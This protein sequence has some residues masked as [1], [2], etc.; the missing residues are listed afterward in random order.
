M[1]MKEK[2]ELSGQ[3]DLEKHLALGSAYL[4][5]CVRQGW[6]QKTGEE[7]NAH[8]LMTETGKKKLSKVTFNLDLSVISTKRDNTK[9]KRKRHK[10]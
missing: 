6:L 1:T 10:K 2:P 7:P 9:K 8:Y 5:Y 3:D 4:D